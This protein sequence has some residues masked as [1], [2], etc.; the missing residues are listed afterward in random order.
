MGSCTLCQYY[1]SLI[2]LG[3]LQNQLFVIFHTFKLSTFLLRKTQFDESWNKRKW[4]NLTWRRRRFN[5]LVILV[6]PTDCSWTTSQ[7][8]RPNN[9]VYCVITG[10]SLN[11]TFRQHVVEK[12]ITEEYSVWELYKWRASNIEMRVMFYRMMYDQTMRCYARM[13]VTSRGPHI[14]LV[15]VSLSVGGWASATAPNLSPI[16]EGDSNTVE[17]KCRETRTEANEKSSHWNTLTE[18]AVNTHI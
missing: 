7:F 12:R 3:Y 14:P 13:W 16:T 9:Y 10:Y 6:K 2:L 17:R 8:P 5:I 11:V 1:K 15:L 4:Q 18:V